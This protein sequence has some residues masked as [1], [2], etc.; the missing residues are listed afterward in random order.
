MAGKRRDV[1]NCVHYGVRVAG[2]HSSST[3][4]LCSSR[5]HKFSAFLITFSQ[6]NQIKCRFIT[7]FVIFCVGQTSAGAKTACEITF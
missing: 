6:K 1:E 5:I 2:G 7:E 4:T 3:R